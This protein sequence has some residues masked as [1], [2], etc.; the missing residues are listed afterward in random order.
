[1]LLAAG[2]AAGAQTTNR[3]NVLNKQVS[4]TSFVIWE[5]VDK[6]STELFKIPLKE[7]TKC[8]IETMSLDLGWSLLR[9][10]MI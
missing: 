1:M 5:W 4:R 7:C 8:S 3:T 9:I 2:L 10:T 6:D